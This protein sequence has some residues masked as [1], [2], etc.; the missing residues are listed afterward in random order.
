MRIG[1]LSDPELVNS[2]YRAYQPLAAVA[3]R[4]RHE[5]HRNFSDR[6]LGSEVLLRS[7]VVHIHRIATPDT[8]QLIRRLRDAG[9]GVVWD[10]DDDVMS[11]PRA[12][13][14]YRR[15]G[16]A[17]RRELVAGT[18]QMIRLAD[19]VTTPS[20]LLAARY[21]ELGADD[22]RVL[23]NR[24]P[25]EFSGVRPVAHDGVVIA[26][27][28]GLEHRVDYD[29]LGLRSVLDRLLDAHPDVRL[30][31]IGLGLGLAPDRTEHLPLVRFLELVRTL[32]RADVGLAP[33]TDIAWN[34]ARSNVKLKEY[35]AAGLAWLASPVGPYRAMGEQH[36]GRLVPDVGWYD[37][38][39]QLVVDARTRRKLAKRGAKWVKH[40]GI[41]RHAAEWERALRD[42][43]ARAAARGV[44]RR[45]TA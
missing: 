10:N 28:A 1:L 12:N 15:L 40:E 42:A 23:E 35:A 25:G 3:R 30:L 7:D 33:L 20:E 43:A 4:G 27:L 16:A 34:R 39:E 38:I 18:A 9:V 24:L 32:A 22:V 11:L 29:G 5:V 19:V 31:T 37:A 45:V 36:G 21:R 8:L 2:N 13:P 14:H 44:E 41:D 17:G 6:A 26:C